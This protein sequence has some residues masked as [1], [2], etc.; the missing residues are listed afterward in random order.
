VYSSKASFRSSPVDTSF[1]VFNCVAQHHSAAPQ[2]QIML[3]PEQ[4]YVFSSGQTVL[5]HTGSMKTT[6]S[7]Q[8]TDFLQHR[9]SAV[10]MQA[11]HPTDGTS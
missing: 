4:P 9:T 3:Y 7:T 2:T 8:Q 5:F 10:L 1:R 6:A 11:K